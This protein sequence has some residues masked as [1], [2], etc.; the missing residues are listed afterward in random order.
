MTALAGKCEDIFMTAA[1][2]T[3]AGKSVM[4][5]AAVKVLVYYFFYVGS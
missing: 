1:A 2:A 5:N 3:D 4:K